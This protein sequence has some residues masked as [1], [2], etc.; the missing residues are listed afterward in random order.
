MCMPVRCT[1]ALLRPH[2][3]QKTCKELGW[4]F[5]RWVSG[6]A[7]A[8]TC[9]TSELNG[10]C[11]KA[12]YAGAAAACFNQGARLCTRCAHVQQKP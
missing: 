11:V 10:A 1:C 4:S 12:D 8:A 7:S 6:T 5:S 2:S 9:A 3:S